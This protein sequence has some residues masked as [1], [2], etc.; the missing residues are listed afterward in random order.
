MS[1]RLPFVSNDTAELK[2]LILSGSYSMKGPQWNS[3]STEGR[4]V[5]MNM[6]KINPEERHSALKLLHSHWFAVS[7]LNTHCF[8]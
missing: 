5:V 3:I 2:Q 6:L 7:I 1:G 8:N 4:E